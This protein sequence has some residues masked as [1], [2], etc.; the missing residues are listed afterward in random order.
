TGGCGAIRLS[1]ALGS[2]IGYITPSGTTTVF[3]TA[4]VSRHG[5]DGLT[6]GPGNNIWFIELFHKKIGEITPSGKI[7]QLRIKHFLGPNSITT[8]PDHNLWIS[9]FDNEVGRITPRGVATYFHHKGEHISKVLGFH[10]A[11]YLQENDTIGRI[12]TNGKFTGEFKLPRHGHLQDITA[13][14]DGNVWFTEQSGATDYVGF[15]T[16]G[17]HIHEFPVSKA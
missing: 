11:I 4:R 3:S 13:G 10:G 15:L 7:T 17:G 6:L 16:P 14:P 2:N 5:L 9:T 1:S 12:A 8:G